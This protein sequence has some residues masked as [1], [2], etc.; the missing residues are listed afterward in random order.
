MPN[1]SPMT[2][3]SQDSLLRSALPPG[4]CGGFLAAVFM[5]V[6]WF[7]SHAPWANLPESTALP[8][9]VAAWGGGLF[10]AAAWGVRHAQR[11]TPTFAALTGG[12]AGLTSALLGLLVLGSKLTEAPA[13]G[14]TEAGSLVPNAGLIAVGFLSIAIALGLIAG[15]AAGSF[16][17][18]SS[19]SGTWAG[20]FAVVTCL[21]TAPLLFIGGLVTS[22]DS[23]MAVPD[24]PGTFGSNMF[25]YPLG[26]RVHATAGE[27]Y[28]AVY[29]EHSHR[30][31]GALV[32]LT[33]LTMM[34]WVLC[35]GTTRWVKGWAVALFVFVVVQ[36]VLGGSRVNMDSRVMA[37]IHGVS[38]Q[39]IF[40]GLVGLAVYLSDTYGRI[41]TSG[42]AEPE[43][44]A[45]RRLR[46]FATAA[47]HTLIVQ[48]IFGA[49]YRHFRGNHALWSHAGFSI[50]VVVTTIMAA[51]AT[52][53]PAA[54][55]V[56]PRVL[57]TLAK[58]A[59]AI[60][61]A[62]FLLGWMAFFMGGGN[63]PRAEHAMGAI[64]RTLHQA[65][66]AALLAVVAGLFF[67]GR[68]LAPRK[69]RAAT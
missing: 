54:K 42:H 30:L 12:I 41:E 65:N 62:Q 69:P 46:I 2:S 52:F 44:K 60:V 20:R 1:L 37:M 19:P 40:A 48:L 24:W 55:T 6:A 31:F 56:L 16:R 23:G 33:T 59:I 49:I 43:S 35:S 64:L 13:A 53:A 38:A 51:F 18:A 8:I 5:W 10:L 57:G 68:R 11:P 27:T 22:T 21:V 67:F 14:S 61:A 34:I 3:P 15:A 45:M 26:P 32:G 4:I 17:L 66:G 28:T 29:L 7:V 63:G 39:L 58:A 50:V 25:L 47:M 9:V 36:G